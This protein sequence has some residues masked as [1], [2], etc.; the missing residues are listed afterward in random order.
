MDEMIDLRPYVD[1]LL[2]RRWAIVVATLLGM[3][4]ATV[5]YFSQTSYQARALVV[6]NEP[7][8]ELQFDPRITDITDVSV[9]LHT[10]PE[11]ATSDEVMSLLI[12][13]ARE[14]SDGAINSVTLLRDMMDVEV[15][16]DARL[17]R[18]IVQADS[19][20]LA[21]NLANA[22][23]DILLTT[24]DDMYRSPGGNIDFYN[25]QLA[26]TNAQL[27]TAEQSLVQFQSESRMGLVDNELASLTALQASYLADQRQLSL[28]LD[29]ID[30]LKRQMAAGSGDA[31][32]WADQ[33]T[34]LMLQ[35]DV[36][37]MPQATP[38]AG[39]DIQLQL[40]TQSTLTTATRQEQLQQLDQLAQAAQV[41]LA[42]IDLRL[43]ELEPR[44]F[45]L[46]AEKEEIFHQYEELTR[47]RDVAKETYLTL[48]RKLDEE[49]IST[50]GPSMQLQLASAA[51]VP[52][53]PERTSL[54]LLL[55]LGATA[56]LLISLALVILRAWWRLVNSPAH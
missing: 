19:P 4:L 32:T 48:A 6:I 49:R 38:V 41:S 20:Q 34:A 53:R 18:L 31:I 15:G 50:A 5:Y 28:V 36:Y 21:A 55:V 16:V 30:T 54:P 29:H 9:L 2:R 24:V 8:Q 35:L 25:S 22:W 56:G 37:E 14:L 45:A 27:A 12:D 42:A 7:T 11:L 17:M 51:A 26:Q 47:S 46:Q 13:E 23:A 1:A 43:A 10:Y 52:E 39:S 33:L 44:I 40:D 3:L